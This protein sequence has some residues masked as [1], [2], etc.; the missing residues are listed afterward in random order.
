MSVRTLRKKVVFSDELLASNE[1][2]FSTNKVTRY[3]LNFPII[4]TCAPTAL[5]ADTCYFTKG[6]STWSASLRK[7]YRLMNTV[8]DEPRETAGRIVAWAIRLKIDYI[9]WNGGGDLFPELV[10]CINHTTAV[11]SDR[12]HWVR[13]RKPQ[14]A[15]RIEPRP[16]VYVHLSIDN[17]SWNRYEKMKALAPPSLQWFTAYQCA[18][19]EVPTGNES[20]VIFRDGYKLRGTAPVENDCYLNLTEDITGACGRCRRCFD[21]SAL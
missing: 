10:D 3:S 2:P 19:G 18:P 13:T 16:N 6:P 8:I 5:C 11:L 14:L 17:H 9:C 4:G 7:Q 12:P 1:N 21:G 20:K 15:S